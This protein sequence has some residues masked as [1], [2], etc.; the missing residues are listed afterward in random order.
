MS[1]SENIYLFSDRGHVPLLVKNYIPWKEES[2]I[3][4]EFMH[5]YLKK[6]GYIIMSAYKFS[7]KFHSQYN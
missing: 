2:L 4:E 6:N 3:L 7:F 1:I 5:V